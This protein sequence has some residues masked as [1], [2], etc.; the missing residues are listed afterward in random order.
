MRATRS[1]LIGW[2]LGKEPERP[3]HSLLGRAAVSQVN[4]SGSIKV[5]ASRAP[6][7]RLGQAFASV[8]LGVESVPYELPCSHFADVL[9]FGL[10]DRLEVV[11]AGVDR[12]DFVDVAVVSEHVVFGEGLVPPE[13]DSAFTTLEEPSVE[14]HGTA[15]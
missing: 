4:G 3:P 2:S 15:P 10:D 1:A 6:L 13:L 12:R 11:T 7:L 9:P 14:E 8:G 5:D